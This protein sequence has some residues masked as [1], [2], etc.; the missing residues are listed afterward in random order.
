[1]GILAHVTL[2]ALDDVAHDG[3]RRLFAAIARNGAERLGQEAV[4][5]AAQSRNEDRPDRHAGHPR[6]HERTVRESGGAAEELDLA[7][8]LVA[9][10]AVQLHRDDFAAAQCLDHVERR[11]R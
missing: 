7:S 9:D 5:A 4:P 2:E 3:E 11:E 1:M 10:R 6:Q 8:D